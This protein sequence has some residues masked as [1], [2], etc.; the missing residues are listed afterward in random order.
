MKY[1]IAIIG[2][3]KYALAYA[4]GLSNVIYFGNGKRK[5][6]LFVAPRKTSDLS[7]FEQMGFSV[8][9]DYAEASNAEVIMLLVTPSAVGTVAQGLRSIQFPT[10]YAEKAPVVITQIS[11]LT[12]ETLHTHTG[13]PVGRIIT[14]TGNT[15]VAQGCGMTVLGGTKGPLLDFAQQAL[16]KLDVGTV[17]VIGK[18]KILRSIVSIGSDNAFNAK[19]LQVIHAET[20][21]T[22]PFYKWLQSLAD[23][24]HTLRPDVEVESY[25]FGLKAI[26]TYLLYKAQVFKNVFGYSD[27]WTLVHQSFVSTL[28]ALVNAQVYSYDGI[29]THIKTVTTEGG[30]TMQGINDL[31]TLTQLHD[32]GA[33]SRAYQ[34][35]YVFAKQNFP[36]Q[37]A[38]SLS[39]SI[40]TV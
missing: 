40:V 19:A 13:I 20:E 16:L 24:V 32:L 36:E 1:T 33:L 34:K 9:Y 14:A 12:A 23:K 22:T 6:I 5:K 39:T 4:E 26:R 17:S 25:Y 38:T 30:C 28:T 11:G 10:T 18:R 21:P 3:K 27:A 37:I 35:V 15:N 31:A 2:S 29:Q 8:T 7:R